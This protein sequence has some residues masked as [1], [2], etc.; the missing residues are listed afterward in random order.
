MH[1]VRNNSN[2]EPSSSTPGMGDHPTASALFGVIMM[3]LYKREIT[4]K[5]SEVSSSLMANG[6]WSNGIYIQAALCGANFIEN[7]GRGTK[8]ALAEKYKCKDGRW[9]ILVMLNEEREWPLLLKCLNRE[10]LNDNQKFNTRESRAENSLELLNILDK[11]FLIKDWGELKKLFEKSGV[12]FGPI[13][14]PYDHISDQQIKDNNFFTEFSNK[15]DLLTIDSPIYMKGEEKKQPHTAPKIGEHTKKILMELNYN[16]DEI[17][18]L[19]NKK[20]IKL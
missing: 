3:A 1:A 4:G 14:E 17:K 18:D 9:F 8:G 5:G 15:K 6:L 10:D 7:T 12:T 13:S 2:S 20:I 19:K 16:Q 11:E